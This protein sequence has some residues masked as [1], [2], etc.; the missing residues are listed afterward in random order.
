MKMKKI[1]V[2]PTW[3][4]SR[5]GSRRSSQNQKRA[6]DPN[7][8]QQS[9]PAPVPEG[10][11]RQY[12]QVQHQHIGQE[13]PLVR[14]LLAQKQGVKNPPMMP[15]TAMVK[16]SYLKASPVAVRVIRK[17]SPRASRGGISW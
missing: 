11:Q 1:T 15:R 17:E 8:S 4:S 7:S 16:D 6:R 3:A 12:S 10:C 13:D 5:P 9:E 2:M 14:K